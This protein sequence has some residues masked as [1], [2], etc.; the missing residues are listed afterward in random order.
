MIDLGNLLRRHT[1]KA[2][3]APVTYNLGTFARDLCF[4]WVTVAFLADVKLGVGL[5]GVG[6]ITLGAQAARKYLEPPVKPFWV[7]VGAVSLASGCVELL[8]IGLRHT[9]VPGGATPMVFIAL[10]IALVTYALLRKQ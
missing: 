2:E 10:G 8:G 9:S 5:L 4:L 1:R 7:A 6:V 3:H